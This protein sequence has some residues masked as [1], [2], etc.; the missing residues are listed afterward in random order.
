M[1]ERSIVL[2]VLATNGTLWFPKTH[3]V[4][5]AICDMFWLEFPT[6][7]QQQT[8]TPGKFPTA[9]I[10]GASAA[11][12]F[13]PNYHKSFQTS[14]SVLRTKVPSNSKIEF[15]DQTG[16][17]GLGSCSSADWNESF[18][19]YWHKHHPLHSNIPLRPNFFFFLENG[20]GEETCKM[21]KNI[22][23]N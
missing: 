6:E 18:L 23:Y 3:R 14:V 22:S 15:H 21:L 12:D 17:P 4:G 16:R 5:R 8:G 10:W 19:N 2:W 7:T 9:A 11:M 20:D 1:V 13:V